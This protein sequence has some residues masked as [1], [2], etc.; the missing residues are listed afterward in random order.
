MKYIWYL[1]T[2]IKQHLIWAQNTR[3]SETRK[4]AGTPILRP[5]RRHQYEAAAGRLVDIQSQNDVRFVPLATMRHVAQHFRPFESL[6]VTTSDFAY[7]P[8]TANNQK[9][10][11]VG[12]KRRAV[13]LHDIASHVSVCNN[14]ASRGPCVQHSVAR[15]W[16]AN[17]AVSLA[18]AMAFRRRFEKF[19]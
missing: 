17:Y 19:L 12:P 3:V 8:T 5:L 10:A 2:A 16:N 9:T 6:S 4:R 15:K 18:P 13:P 7:R 14:V 11:D 1:V